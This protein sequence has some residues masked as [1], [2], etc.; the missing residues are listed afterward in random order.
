MSIIL[1][2]NMSCLDTSAVLLRDG[3]VAF[4]VREERLTRRKKTRDFPLNAV[5]MCLKSAGARIEDMDSVAVSWNPAINM[6]RLNAA[7]SGVARYKPEHFYGV[8]SY[9]FTL[10][11]E[12]ATEFSLQEFAF[13]NGKRLKIHYLDH[14]RCHAADA[15]YLSPFDEAAVL[16]MDAYG[17]K[18]SAAFWVGRGGELRLLRSI[19]FPHSIGS[20]YGTFT[21]FLGFTPDSDE[22]KVMGASAFGNPD[23]YLDTVRKMLHLTPDGIEIDVSY[24]YYPMG[25]RPTA[26]SEKFVREMGAPRRSDEEITQRHYDIAAAVQRHSEDAIMH[27]LQRLHE[28]TGM[29]NVCLGGGVAMNCVANGMVVEKTP[30]ENL[31]VSSS[32]DDGGTSIGAALYAHN[33]LLGG[34]RAPHEAHNFWGPGYDEAEIRAALDLFRIRCEKTQDA[35]RVAAELI[36][37]GKIVAWFTGR[38]EFGERALGHRSIICDPRDAS[39]KDRVNSAVKFREA[40]RP[41]APSILEEKTA[42]Y[43]QHPVPTPFM[44][45][46]LSVIPEKRS[47]IPAVVHNDGTARL[48]TVPASGNDRFR[49]LIIEFEKLTGIPIVLNT[50]FNLQG[51]PIVCNPKDAIRT[52]FT[53]GLDALFLEDY[54]IKK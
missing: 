40:F 15:F 20:F 34:T 14:H 50:S 1:G 13:R 36:A 46:A 41:F 22:W 53:S 4:A 51:E 37:A 2:I 9:L 45:K 32:P 26:Y 27:L 28:L 7:Q 47:L 42:E 12:R 48:Q 6:E 43:F 30:F 39:M 49:N 35:H 33:A 44:E 3:A 16:T 10:C 21:Q 24:F 52:F 31:F 8:P 19:E 25:S 11:E 5:E 17:E 18:D 38:L 29:K 54:L 23:R